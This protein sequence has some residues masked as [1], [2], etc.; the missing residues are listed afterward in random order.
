[1][2]W[3]AVGERQG[4]GRSSDESMEAGMRCW[5]VVGVAAIAGCAAAAPEPDAVRLEQA[6]A[7]VVAGHVGKPVEAVAATL[8]PNGEAGVSVVVVTDASGAGGERVHTCEV[9]AAGRV[10]AIRHP[11]A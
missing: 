4:Q 7:A 6:C 2:S 5:Q 8:G 11:G 9:D 10:L 3:L 1:M